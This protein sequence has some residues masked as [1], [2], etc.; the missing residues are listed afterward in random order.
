VITQNNPPSKYSFLSIV[1]SLL[2]LFRHNIIL[3]PFNY[4][5][6]PKGQTYVERM[7]RTLQEEFMMYY[8]DCELKN[9]YEL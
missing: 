2:I 8:E 7:N 4:P 3:T 5:R 6:Y 9:V 1:I